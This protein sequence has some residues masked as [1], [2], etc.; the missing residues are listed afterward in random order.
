MNDGHVVRGG[1]RV[2]SAPTRV[3]HGILVVSFGIAYLSADSDFWQT[4]HFTMGYT[5][6]GA[7]ALRLLWGMVGPRSEH[8]QV[9]LA[10]ARSVWAWTRS[11][12]TRPTLKELMPDKVA[13][14]ALGV[15]IIALLVFVVGAATTGWFMTLDWAGGWLGDAIS[16]LHEWLA[17]AA[18]ATLCLHLGSA[19]FLAWR[20]GAAWL[21]RMWHGRVPGA[22]PDLV[23][24]NGT[25][26]AVLLAA[27]TLTF[28][29][30]TWVG[31]IQLAP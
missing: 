26:V 12:L 5:A 9:W 15:S 22:G 19:G 21:M 16:E 30:G 18:V 3:L 28:W 24:F 4:L 31:W 14:H 13:Q 23:K 20:R 25:L 2:V 11:I 1:R 6:V 7:I 10:R 17:N 27:M 29:L 8:P